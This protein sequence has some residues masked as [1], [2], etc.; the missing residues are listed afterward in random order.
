M[1]NKFK[2]MIAAVMVL[3]IVVIAQ[4]SI[5]SDIYM[6]VIYVGPTIT[7]IPTATPKPTECLVQYFHGQKLKIC[8]TDINQKPT[9][10]PLDE[11]VAIKNIGSPVN[12]VDMTGWFINSDSSTG[13]YFFPDGF[14]IKVGQT[15]KI[16]TRSGNDGASQLYMDR[17]EEFW[18]DNKDCGYLK[19]EDRNT[20][21]AFCYGVSGFSTAADQ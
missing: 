12:P 19:D 16:Y 11:W 8:F 1:S 21:N 4:A 13:K 7:P 14:E 10:S 5:L 6:P 20:I 9:S 18:K 3:G 17:T 15:V 2:W